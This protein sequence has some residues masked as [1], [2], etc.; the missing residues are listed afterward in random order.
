M[1]AQ[2]LFCGSHPGEHPAHVTRR[3]K[4]AGI[5]ALHRPQ[6][7]GCG[8]YTNYWNLK[9]ALDIFR[10]SF[11]LSQLVPSRFLSCSKNIAWSRMFHVT[12]W[13]K[14][15]LESSTMDAV[16]TS[17]TRR[18][19]SVTTVGRWWTKNALIELHGP[20]PKCKTVAETVLSFYHSLIHCTNCWVF[21]ARLQKSANKIPMTYRCFLM[22]PVWPFQ[23]QW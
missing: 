13:T 22:F 8:K 19:R 7:A 5:E 6:C 15:R 14:G 11:C 12:N 3:P 1:K 21:Q 10:L 4:S 9:Y 17:I 16:D 2:G 18:Q 20:W 23:Y